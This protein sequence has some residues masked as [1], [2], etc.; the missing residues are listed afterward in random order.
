MVVLLG[1]IG[2]C[3]FVGGGGV[4]VLLGGTGVCV[5]VGGT[6]VRVLLGGTGVCVFV[7]GTGVDVFV[8]GSVGV[9]VG[10]LVAVG[11]GE[12]GVGDSN[13]P[14]SQRAPIGRA[15]FRWS[16]ATQLDG[17]AVSMAG[18]PWASTSAWVSVGPPLLAS[19][20]L[21]TLPMVSPSPTRFWSPVVAGQP[22]G[23]PNRL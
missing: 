23:L 8:G 3:V 4:R 16:V 20:V 9:M 13:E 11:V 12:G 14:L 18:L 2:V 21:I 1:G 5:F 6:A 19:V 15:M 22:A 17:S 10:V 7:G